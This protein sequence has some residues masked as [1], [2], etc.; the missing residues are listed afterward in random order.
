MDN[1]VAAFPALESLHER[2]YG[3]TPVVAKYYAESA[4]ICMQRHHTSPKSIDVVDDDSDRRTYLAFYLAFWNV[5]SERHLAAWRND[6]QATDR[7]AYGMAVA[8]AEVYLGLFV[9]AQAPQGSGSDYLFGP[10]LAEQDVDEPLDLEERATCRLEVSG[11]YRCDGDRHFEGR[12]R[13]KVEQLARGKSPLP[14]IAGVVAF[15]LARIR[16]RRL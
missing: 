1:N 7:A 4:A 14:G 10:P 13:E 5:P 6:P 11:I 9:V 15:N 16:F 2:H 12:V 8:A 3:L